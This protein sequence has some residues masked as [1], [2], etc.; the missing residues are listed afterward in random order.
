VTDGAGGVSRRTTLKLAGA[1]AALTMLRPFAWAE[2]KSGLHGLSVFGDLKYPPD[3]KHFDYVNPDAPKGG[4]IRYQPPNWLYNQ[5]TQ[6]FNTLNSFVLRGDSPPR[7]GLVFDTLMASAAD[8]PDSVYGLVAESVAVSDDGKIFTFTL[9]EEARFHDG[10]PLTAE[11]VAFSLMLLKEKGHPNL[12]QDIKE[13]VSAEALD[14]KTVA[15]TLS[16]KHNR[17]TILTITALPIFSKSYYSTREFDSSTLEPPL[18]S[19]AYKVGRLSAGRFIEFERVADYW[20]KDLPVNVGFNNFDVVRIDFFVERQVAFEAFK[21]GEITHR[22]EFTSITWAQDYNFPAITS[23]KVKKSLFPAEMRPSMQGWFINTRRKK[24]A[25]PRTRR[26]IGLAFDF[27]WSN[28]NLF[29]GSY[30]RLASFF[31]RSDFQADGQPTADELALLEPLRQDLRP[32]VF[33]EA[34]VPPQGDG[35]GRDRKLLRRASDLLAAAGWRQEG[36]R[37]V[38]ESGTALDIEFLIDGAVFER[39]LTPYVA[40]L[41]AIGIP[42]TIRQVDPVQAEARQTDFDF[43]VIMYALSLAATPL[44]GLQQMFSSSA[45]DIK[46]SFNLSGVREKAID[47]ILDKLPE[48]NS[49]E[50][51]IAITR[52]IDRIFR[53][54]HYWVPNWYRADHWVAHWDIFGWPAVK[55]DYAFTP[56]LTWWF[57]KDRATEIGM[58]G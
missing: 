32:E 13:M 27:E 41:K 21:K 57:D 46:G 50:E 44:D 16:G 53:A 42:A 51:L 37:L 49:R 56:E 3:F 20:A 17:Y 4:T 30:T 55:P 43:D 10:S 7:M 14:A 12:A 38:D 1:A 23:G 28:R 6:T 24:F 39:V 34:V 33:G 35:S 47:A 52:S 26:A 54:G 45:A 19:G 18:G 2:G 11:D 36:G 15:V 40:N 5:N 22:E 8:E 25:D 58:A 31:G 48:V 29:Y 9:R